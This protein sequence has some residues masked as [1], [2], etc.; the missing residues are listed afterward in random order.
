ML[1]QRVTSLVNLSETGLVVDE[2]TVTAWTEGGSVST[3]V[4][5]LSLTLTECGATGRYI[6]G[7]VPTLPGTTVVRL[8]VDAVDVFAEFSVSQDVSDERAPFRFQ[9]IDADEAVLSNARVSLY[10]GGVRVFSGVTGTDGYVDGWVPPGT[11]TLRVVKDG[12]SPNVQSIT[13]GPGDEV[14]PL[15][16]SAFPGEP[17]EDA[18]FVLRG[19]ALQDVTL[20]VDGAPY[21]AAEAISPEATLLYVSGL[22]A[23]IHTLRVRRAFG[24]GYLYSNTLPVVVS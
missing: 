5:T 3:P 13:V 17:A 2:I 15:L 8:V 7:I 12:F 19:F 6:L 23:G 21:A 22:S 16:T 18:S 10:N 4:S 9:A 24:E 11:Y 20:S 1:G 14:L